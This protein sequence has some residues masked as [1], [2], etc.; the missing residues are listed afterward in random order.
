MAAA[1]EPPVPTRLY[2]PLNYWRIQWMR[3]KLEHVKDVV[4]WKSSSPAQL[5]PP[6]NFAAS[7]TADKMLAKEQTPSVAF[8]TRVLVLA[9]RLRAQRD[10]LSDK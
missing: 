8:E 1:W 6:R 2:K 9:D 4:G 5:P 7:L 3:K 10:L